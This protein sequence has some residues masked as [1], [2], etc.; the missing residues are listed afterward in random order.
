MTHTY[1]P[2]KLFTPEQANAML[3]LV[4]AIVGDL[5]E[6]SG[7]A[8]ERR[9]RLQNLLNGRELDNEDPYSEELAEVERELER[10]MERIRGFAQ[11]LED[12]GIELKDPVS[13]LIDFPWDKD[14]R[15]VYLCWKYNEP[16]VGHWHELDAGFRGRQAL[17]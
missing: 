16:T 13:G 7:S 4:R 11:E 5:V 12:L 3:P 17:S 8:L 9:E 2:A 1:Q 6:I 10:D 15:T 14:G